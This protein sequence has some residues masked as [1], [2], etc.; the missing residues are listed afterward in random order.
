MKNFLKYSCSFLTLAAS[1]MLWAEDPAAIQE[2]LKQG[3][4]FLNAGDVK[5]AAAIAE[6]IGKQENGKIEAAFFKLQIA[7]KM[8]DADGVKKQIGN[9]LQF[10]IPV[11]RKIDAL[12]TYAR[13]CRSLK[14]MDE[15]R[16]AYQD[17]LNL[18][19]D[20]INHVYAVKMNIADTYWNADKKQHEKLLLEL[21]HLDGITNDQKLRAMNELC[22]K[23]YSDMTRND[24]LLKIVADAEKIPNLT[25]SQ[26]LNLLSKRASGLVGKLELDEAKALFDQFEKDNPEAGVFPSRNQFLGR[27]VEFYDEIAEPG[28]AARI[29]LD[30]LKNEHGY[31]N[32]NIR[33][34]IEFFAADNQLEYAMAEADKILKNVVLKSVVHHHFPAYAEVISAATRFKRFEDAEKFVADA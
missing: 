6:Q 21:Y 22:S 26:K 15:C 25:Y 34:M 2:L 3:N 17:S 27:K 32:H 23:L 29:Y 1:C 19:P 31:S 20:D 5:Q 14:K 24:D 13:L 12:T 28:N 18:K 11:N 33:R 9:I 7:N 4:Q 16:Q 10:D 8:Q 30:M